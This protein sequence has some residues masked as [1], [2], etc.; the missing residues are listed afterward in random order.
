MTTPAKPA[1]ETA[2][3]EPVVQ[4]PTQTTEIE[5]PYAEDPKPASFTDSVKDTA[6]TYADKVKVKAAD[7]RAQLQQ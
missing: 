4:P 6:Q 7:S 3:V 5:K 1:T 2:T